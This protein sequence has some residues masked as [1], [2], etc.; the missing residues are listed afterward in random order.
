MGARGEPGGFL[1]LDCGC[2][3]LSPKRRSRGLSGSQRRVDTHALART[4]IG[5]ELVNASLCNDLNAWRNTPELINGIVYAAGA[6]SIEELADPGRVPVLGYWLDPG[7]QVFTSWILRPGS[8][9]LHERSLD[10]QTLTLA[11]PSSRVRRVVEQTDTVT[12]SV[13][14]EIDA[15]RVVVEL[16]GAGDED[17]NIN[18]SGRA[19][20]AGYTLVCELGD[21]ARSARL[22]EF[23]RT[24]RS[25]LGI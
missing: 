15:D 8:F 10:G 20:H 17:G 19:L 2:P 9:V 5:V 18:L 23:A 24:A 11:V 21:A 6:R 1:G 16:G 25:G 22:A 4:D 14:I 12:S 3:G 13:T 7:P